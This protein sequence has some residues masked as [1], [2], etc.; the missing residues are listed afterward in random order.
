MPMVALVAVLAWLVASIP[1]ALIM[2]RVLAGAS[3]D[4]VIDLRDGTP[5]ADHAA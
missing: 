5:T 1:V 3:A 2:G 4:P